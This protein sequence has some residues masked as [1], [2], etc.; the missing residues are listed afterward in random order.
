MN[1]QNLTK[2]CIHIFRMELLRNHFF[3]IS[4]KN[5]TILVDVIMQKEV[6]SIRCNYYRK[7]PKFLDTRKLCCNH[8]KLE[9]RDF[10][11]E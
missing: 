11:I 8:P 2:F 9:K 7:V 4:A 3:T 5:K 6:V 10:T 1:G